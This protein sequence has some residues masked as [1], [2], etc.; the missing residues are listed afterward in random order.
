METKQIIENEVTD[1]ASQ[2]F[3]LDFVPNFHFPVPR[4]R[5]RFPFPLFCKVP[6][7]MH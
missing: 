6:I 2:V 7:R 1:R 4:V 3:K 5:C